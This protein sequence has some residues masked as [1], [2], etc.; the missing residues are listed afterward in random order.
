MA[1][2]AIKTP[3]ALSDRI[4]QHARRR[5]ADGGRRDPDF[6]LVDQLVAMPIPRLEP[7]QRSNIAALPGFV[8]ATAYY[9]RTPPDENAGPP[10]YPR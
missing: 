9:P 1:C 10:Y 6:A 8:G 7:C 5:F 4:R 3:L 2:T